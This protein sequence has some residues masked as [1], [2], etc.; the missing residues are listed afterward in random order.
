[1][2]ET[3]QLALAVGQTHTERLPGLAA[4]G[5]TWSWSTEGDAQA[6]SV[7][8]R[9]DLPATPPA[10]GGPPPGT[11]SFDEWV[12]LQALAPGSA[13]IRFV[14]KRPW[15]RNQPPREVRTFHVR[16]SADGAGPS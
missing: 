4:A 5:Y 6:V 1:M 2:E 16:V 11:A 15:E 12:E 14:L 3:R 7:S 10:P 9:R 8:L 13:V